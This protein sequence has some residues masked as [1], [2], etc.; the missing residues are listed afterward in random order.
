MTGAYS[1]NNSLYHGF[2]YNTV[3]QTFTA[4][5]DA[6]GAAIYTGGIKDFCCG[7]TYAMGIDSAGDITAIVMTPLRAL[8][9]RPTVR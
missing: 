3:T 7:G 6:P 8:L 9:R 5:I 2:I 4:P 1:D